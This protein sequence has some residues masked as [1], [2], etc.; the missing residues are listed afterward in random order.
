MSSLL[1]LESLLD[2]LPSLRIGVVGDFC[3]DAY[4]ELDS[5]RSEQSVETG[6]PT[7]PVRVQRYSLGAAGNVANNL[8]AMGVGE[9][10]VYGVTGS[11]PFGFEMRKLMRDL[12][13]RAD[14]LLEQESEWTT[15]AY[16]KPVEE[17]AES[18][19][20]DFGNFNQLSDETA[21]QVAKQ[22]SKD[23]AELDA[24][25]INQQVVAGIHNLELFQNELQSLVSAHPEKIA[26]LDSRDMSGRYAGTIRK[27]NAHEAM[28]L[29]GGQSD[30][31]DP[32][33]LDDARAAAAKLSVEWGMPL[34]VTL[35]P[36]GC[37]VAEGDS[38][39]LASCPPTPG[40]TDPVGAGDSM[41]SGIAAAL[42]TG[43]SPLES[44]TFGNLVATVTVQKLYQTG[45]A[46]PDEIRAVVGSA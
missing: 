35:G 3:L 22:L 21:R 40:S 30:P 16:I 25:I 42:A 14:G 28:L 44:A 39:E 29:M 15:H 43:L 45:T 37:L 24:L 19:R 9:V 13:I 26:L 36:R 11:D 38:V 5:S 23:L 17:G 34:F 12:D 41:V 32:V 4:W 27:F 10:S 33:S 46:T 6:L 7:R 18:N 31:R 20:M 8:K 2:E 1:N